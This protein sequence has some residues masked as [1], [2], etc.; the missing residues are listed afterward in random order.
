MT[1]VLLNVKD[2][3][4]KRLSAFLRV[5]T[6]HHCL[7]I[8]TEF[9]K[10]TCILKNG[11]TKNAKQFSLTFRHIDDVLSLNNSNFSDIIYVIY[12]SELGLK[13]TTDSTNSASYLDKFTT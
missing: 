10:I 5:L 9:I 2:I 8:Y 4:F 12:L 11:D 13:D 7:P 6:I 1:I 3:F